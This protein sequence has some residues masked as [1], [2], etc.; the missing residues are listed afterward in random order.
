MGSNYVNVLCVGTGPD[1]LVCTAETRMPRTVYRCSV[2]NETHETWGATT[3]AA[4]HYNPTRFGYLPSFH[5]R[6]EDG[7]SVYCSHGYDTTHYYNTQYGYKGSSSTF[8]VYPVT[9]TKVGT[10]SSTLQVSGATAT[11]A[12]LSGKTVSLNLSGG[13]KSQ[14]LLQEQHRQS[15]LH[16]LLRCLQSLSHLQWNTL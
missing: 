1:G 10:F 2:C 9:V 5:Y 11:D 8:K 7:E 16:T 12:A 14:I 6:E 3:C 4:G 15:L 13:T